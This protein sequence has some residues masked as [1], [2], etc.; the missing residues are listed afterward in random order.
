MCTGREY[1]ERDGREEREIRQRVVVERS[2]LEKVII[3]KRDTRA[4]EER[5]Q[6]VVGRRE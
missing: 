3:E 6:R 2:K 5:Q 1:G 4:K